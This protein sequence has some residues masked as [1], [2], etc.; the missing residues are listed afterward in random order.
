MLEPTEYLENLL[1]EITSLKEGDGVKV[2]FKF[3]VLRQ[4]TLTQFYESYMSAYIKYLSEN[5]LIVDANPDKNNIVTRTFTDLGDQFANF[6]FKEDPERPFLQ[7]GCHFTRYPHTKLEFP[8]GIVLRILNTDKFSHM[9]IPKPVW[10][11][12]LFQTLPQD[13]QNSMLEIKCIAKFQPPNFGHN[14]NISDLLVKAMF[15]LYI[16]DIS[17]KVEKIREIF[18]KYEVFLSPDTY[19]EME[20]GYPSRELKDEFT[21]FVLDYALFTDNL[22]RDCI[23]V[24][25]NYLGYI[26]NDEIK[27]SHPQ[28]FLHP[29]DNQFP[30]MEFDEEHCLKLARYCREHD[31][32][33]S[34]VIRAKHPKTNFIILLA[35]AD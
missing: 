34:D 19:N 29:P 9:R 16:E 4:L 31:I 18:V 11:N 26:K 10:N 13:V 25:C 33:V 22:Q 32:K 5:K 12:S 1:K 17:E 21:N 27:Y 6:C 8:T 20:R 7:Y 15:D 2:E 30:W 14:K 28:Y 35:L 23:L 3:D 24:I